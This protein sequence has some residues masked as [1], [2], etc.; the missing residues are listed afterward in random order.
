M[1]TI[2]IP[3]TLLEF[4]LGAVVGWVILLVLAWLASRRGQAREGR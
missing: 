2:S 4:M 3:A 1:I